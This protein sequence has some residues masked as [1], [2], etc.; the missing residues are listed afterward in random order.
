MIPC[1]ENSLFPSFVFTWAN[2]AF[3]DQRKRHN[4]VCEEVI[5]HV[6]DLLQDVG[7]HARSDRQN[8]VNLPCIVLVRLVCCEELFGVIPSFANQVVIHALFEQTALELLLP[9]D[10]VEIPV[11]LNSS[12]V[13]SLYKF[14]QLL[15]TGA[16]QWCAIMPVEEAVGY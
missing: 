6:L 2:I 10:L 4:A 15:Q 11:L 7:L 12:L 16:S 14:S 1:H 5:A 3:S 13:R 9:E 8:A